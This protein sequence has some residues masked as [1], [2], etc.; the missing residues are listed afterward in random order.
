MHITIQETDGPDVLRPLARAIDQIADNR[1]PE[2]STG[3]E[4]VAED[5]PPEK[6]PSDTPPAPTENQTPSPPKEASPAPSAPNDTP[7]PPKEA[8]TT[9]LPPAE[10]TQTPSPPTE[11][12]AAPVPPDSDDAVGLDH[13]FMPWDSRIHSSSQKKTQGGNWKYVRNGDPAERKAVEAEL[14]ERGYGTATAPGKVDAPATGVAQTQAP[15][16]AATTITALLNPEELTYALVIKSYNGLTKAGKI[17]TGDMNRAL[18][19][20]GLPV[21]V[22]LASKDLTTLQTFYASLTEGIA[23]D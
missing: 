19:A 16:N 13:N 1:Q 7:P 20:V 23:H 5:L 18:A 2:V 12:A 11:E 14:R 21:F 8:S 10:D 3:G 9:P 6:G 22:A 15:A 17:N 4:K